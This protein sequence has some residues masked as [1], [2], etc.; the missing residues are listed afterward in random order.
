MSRRRLEG[1]PPQRPPR[2][3]IACD[4]D[5]SGGSQPGSWLSSQSRKEDQA[6]S[7]IRPAHIMLHEE[8]SFLFCSCR[9][10]IPQHV[11]RTCAPRWPGDDV[12]A[13]CSSNAVQ[14]PAGL[15]AHQH[16]GTFVGR[17]VPASPLT[18]LPPFAASCCFAV[19]LSLVCTSPSSPFQRSRSFRRHSLAL[20]Q[21]I[22]HSSSLR[23][24][25]IFKK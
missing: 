10:S 8:A 19:S 2:R 22:D 17:Y 20:F 25:R 15:T 9:A 18:G 23:H 4:A 11:R 3:R 7:E 6:T 12:S 16:W 14:L 24:T 13:A 5:G 21:L 1:P